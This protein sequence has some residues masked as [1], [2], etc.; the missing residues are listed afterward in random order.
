M[1]GVHRPLHGQGMAG[2]TEPALIEKS[3]MLLFMAQAAGCRGWEL[4]LLVIV[5]MTGIAC[6]RPL[7]GSRRSMTAGPPILDYAGGC[8]LVALYAFRRGKTSLHKLGLRLMELPWIPIFMHGVGPPLVGVKPLPSPPLLH[9]CKCRNTEEKKN[10]EY[11][12]I[13]GAENPHN[14]P[15]DASNPRPWPTMVE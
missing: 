8:A 15:R 10:R 14:A 11:Q 4:K 5:A 7:A 9:A 6:N 12:G 1:D 13:G 3:S 2:K